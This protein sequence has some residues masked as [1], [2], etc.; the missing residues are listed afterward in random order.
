MIRLE[1]V[2]FRYP[3][4]SSWPLRGVSVEFK[5]GELVVV[6]GP[7]GS[8][9]TT[10]LKI[11]SLLYRPTRGAVYANGVNAWSLS[12]A[13]R[14]RLRRLLVYVPE[15]PVVLSGTVYSNLAI[16]LRF[17]GLSEEEVRAAVTEI[18]EELG[19]SSLLDV[20]ARTLSSGQRQLVSIARALA[21]RPSMLFLDEPFA[22]LDEDNRAIIIE[23]LERR[24]AGGCGIVLASHIYESISGMRVDR[25][26]RMPPCS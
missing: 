14:T 16:G 22:N 24:R 20:E 13:E 2:W 10:L 3:G 1:N 11:A 12:E 19:M 5:A 25:E 17:R 15:K 4:G 26:L 6:K 9:K 8:G 7:N 21:L 18:A 23:S